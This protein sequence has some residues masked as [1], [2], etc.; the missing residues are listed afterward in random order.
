MVE[1]Q[2]PCLFSVCFLNNVD[3]IDEASDLLPKRMTSLEVTNYS[4]SLWD[5]TCEQQQNIWVSK[6]EQLV[7][8]QYHYLCHKIPLLV[9]G[10][11]QAILDQKVMV[12][13]SCSG[14]GGCRGVKEGHVS[15]NN[16][17]TKEKKTTNKHVMSICVHI[18]DALS[19]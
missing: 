7:E 9:S 4:A 2:I 13:G 19:T 12:P 10:A 14:L 17:F 1:N 16:A 6:E 15:L 11:G 18:I 8:K 3:N 5:N